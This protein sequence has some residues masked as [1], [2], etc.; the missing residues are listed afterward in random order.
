LLGTPSPSVRY[1]AANTLVS[2]TSSAMAVRE[3]AKCFIDLTVK[4]ADNNIKLIV[5]DRLKDLRKDFANVIDELA[6]DVLRVL[7][8]PDIEV[9]RKAI[10]IVLDTLSSRNVSEVVG[11]LKKEIAKTYEAQG[12]KTA[13]Y[14]QLLIHAIHQCAMKYPDTAADVIH[15]LIEFLSDTN[16]NAAVDVVLFVREAME[17]NPGLRET[18]L[19]KLL[20]SFGE[21]K[22]AKVLRG[23]LWILGEYCQ[24]LP[25]IQSA[26]N[27][28]KNC[29]GELPLLIDSDEKENA[30]ASETPANG[31]HMFYLMI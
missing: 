13:D 19:E 15:V 25:L 21:I 2:L 17:R 23:A 18:I 5:L 20:F 11:F 26:L 22:T 6:M 10:T 1:E 16:S 7:S 29:I 28:I 3:V 12:E 31:S 27:E 14:R 4:E 24:S 30:A 9:C 8:S